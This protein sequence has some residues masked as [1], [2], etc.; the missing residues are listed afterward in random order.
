ME[1]GNENDF[2]TSGTCSLLR[3]SPHRVVYEGRDDR[4]SRSFLVLNA[5]VVTSFFSPNRD[6]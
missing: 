5:D 1:N 4:G 3:R 2:L 6:R